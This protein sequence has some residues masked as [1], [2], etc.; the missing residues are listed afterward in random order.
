MKI[1]CQPDRRD[2]EGCGLGQGLLHP[3]EAAGRE[4][5]ERKGSNGGEDSEGRYPDLDDVREGYRPHA[6]GHRVDD[7]E[8]RRDHGIATLDE[9]GSTTLKTVPRRWWG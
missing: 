2:I 3:G 1:V 8:A 7:D 6:A 5:D 4:E 9:R